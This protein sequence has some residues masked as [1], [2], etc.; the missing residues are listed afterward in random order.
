MNLM[1]NK[2]YLRAL[3]KAD[4]PFLNDLINDEDIENMIVGWS[5]PVNMEEQYLWFENLKNDSNIR[6]A[7]C[8]KTSQDEAI[9]TVIVSKIDWKNSS[10]SIDIKLSQNVAGSGIGTDTIRTILKYVFNELNL[11]RVYVN[12]L[13]YNLA[14]QKVFQKC[15]F[16]LEGEQKQAIFKKGKYHNL[17]LYAILREEFCNE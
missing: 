12:I 5:K 17:L 2:V 14:S 4:M 16:K 13:D 7:I 9:G 6:F 10:A 8:K 3:S 15:G 1:G 11:N